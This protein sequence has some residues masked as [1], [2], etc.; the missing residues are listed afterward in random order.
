MKTRLFFLIRL[1][2]AYV[3]IFVLFKPVFMLY[4]HHTADFT[5]HDVLQVMRHGVGLDF[6]TAGYLMGLPLLLTIISVWTEKLRWWRPAILF[7]VGITALAVSIIL[8]TDCAL[9]PFWGFKLDST[10]FNYIDSPKNALSSVSLVFVLAGILCVILFFVL[11]NKLL[12]STLPNRICPPFHYHTTTFTLVLFGGL[13][14]LLIRGGV[15]KSTM[16]IGSVYYSDRQ[17][18]NHAAVNPAFNLLASAL[19]EKKYDK[20]YRFYSSGQLESIL[21]S[22]EH[23]KDNLPTSNKENTSSES[24]L[25]SPRPNIILIIME[26]FAGTFIEPL[27]GEKG[28]TPCFNK[29]IHEG[30][31]FDRF[32]ANSYRTDRGTVCILSGYPAFPKV[33]PMKIPEKSR[34]LGSLAKSLSSQGYATDFLY[35]GDINFT[36]MKSYLLANGYQEVL[37]DTYFPRTQRKTHAWGVTDCITFDTLYQ[38]TLRQPEKKPWFTTFLTLA[39]HEPWKVPFQRKDLHEKA[40]TMAY[41]DHCL[42]TFI[43][44]LRKTPQ[45]KNL[46]V[47]CLP[48]HGINYPEGITE[49]NPQRS[50]I[51]MLWLGGAIKSP[52]I[53]HDICSQTDVA[54]TLLGQ[55]RIDH[56]EYTFS[57]DIMSTDYCHPY[58]F[59]TFDN[60]FSLIDPTGYTAFD[61][62]SGRIISASSHH[63]KEHISL[64]KA[65]LQKSMEDFSKR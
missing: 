8:V 23:R 58:A 41:L 52:R 43:E 47:I 38:R 16:N 12:R 4:N 6:S 31:F 61:L 11:A 18:L 53:V 35:G 45:W 24:L 33:S 29:L 34:S 62:T 56:S 22:L 49:D 55:L 9:Y 28:V 46:L 42:G 15:G 40:N 39:S 30:V 13:T 64:G 5:F 37:G 59:H 3:L 7:Y 27:G 60:G 63:S 44:R 51:P 36:N 25:A 14:F 10:I 50:H 65:L 32:Y 57:H 2:M 48:D 21:D 20:M 1:Y 17:F 26:G 19:K 54:A